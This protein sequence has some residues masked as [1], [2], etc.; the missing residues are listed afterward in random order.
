MKRT[1]TFSALLLSLTLSAPATL[2]A[3]LVDVRSGFELPGSTAGSASG[4]ITV[5]AQTGQSSDALVLLH[6]QMTRMRSELEAMRGMVEEQANEIRR[7]QRDTRDRYTDLDSRISALYQ[8]LEAGGAQ[9][10]STALIAPPVVPVLPQSEQSSSDSQAPS[11]MP[12]VTDTS[13]TGGA[14]LPDAGSM[15]EQQLYQ[16]ALDVLLQEA[17]YQRSIDEFEQY[18][19]IYPDGRFANNAYYWS[20]QAYVNLGEFERARSSFERI[21]NDSPDGGKLDDAMYSLGTV[22]HRLGDEQRARDLLRQ[23]MSRFP[24]TSAANLADI[25]LRSL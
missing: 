24:N 19:A 3:A 21:V 10:P 17:R 25:Y 11:Q 9:A 22:Y 4:G 15:T 13:G 5:Y 14:A 6:D 2:A 8:D 7:L 16:S 23:V 20:G 18:L 1:L 12:Q